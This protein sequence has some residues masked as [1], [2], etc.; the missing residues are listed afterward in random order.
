MNCVRVLIPDLMGLFWIVE[1]ENSND[2]NS[3][4][5]V[6]IPDLMGLFWIRGV[7]D[8]VNVDYVLIP[9]LMGLFWIWTLDWTCPK[10]TCLNPR[11]DG[12]FLNCRAPTYCRCWAVLIPDLMG[13]FW[14]PWLSVKTI[15]LRVLIPDLM[16][17]FWIN[18][19]RTWWVNIQCLNPRFDGAFLNFNSVT[20]A[21]VERPS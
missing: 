1:L 9:D 21:L 16:G 3:T 4:I 18:S 2:G 13:L 15:P 19:V 10:T 17:L 12:A 7:H 5:S 20:V 6:L 8:G 11:F 14:I